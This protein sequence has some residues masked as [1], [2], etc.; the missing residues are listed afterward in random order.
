MNTTKF[1][2]VEITWFGHASFK[3]KGNAGIVYIDPYVIPDSAEAADVIV[4]TH[5]HFDHCAVEN[6]GKIMKTSTVIITT[7]GCARRCSGDV[8]VIKAGDSVEIGEIKVEAVEAYNKAKPFHPRGL[9]VGVVVSINDVRIYHAGDTDFIPEM[10]N[11]KADVALLPA[12]GHYTMDV[13]EAAEAALAIKPSVVIPMHY[14]YIPQTSADP[15]LFRKLV[16]EK[17]ESIEV[18]ILEP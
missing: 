12:G 3:L 17:D 7:Q 14:N 5:E 16:A 2:G 10:S 1:K 9:G 15:E 13:R 18:R 4:M 11:V 8:R 6:A